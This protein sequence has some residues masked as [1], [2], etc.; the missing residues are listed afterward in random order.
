VELNGLA[1]TLSLV[2]SFFLV[3]L[4]EP[5]FATTFF[6]PPADFEVA[7][8]DCAMGTRSASCLLAIGLSLSGMPSVTKGFAAE[9]TDKR[10][11]VDRRGDPLPP[12]ARLR[13]GTTRWRHGGEIIAL[14]FAPDGRSVATMGHDNTL[15]L[16]DIASGKGLAHFHAPNGVAVAFA[17]DGQSLLWCDARGALYRCGAGRRGEDLAGQSERVHSFTLGSEQIETVAFAPDGSTAAL[18]T[19]GDHV[20]LWGHK[21]EIK[22][23]GG[24][25]ALAMSADGR[26]V[27]MNKGREG[28]ELFDV[29]AKRERRAGLSFGTDAVRS[30]AFAA[31]GRTLAAG[32]YENRIRLWDATTGREIRMLEGH[33]RVPVSGKNGVFCLA[34]APGGTTLASGGADGTVRVWDVKTGKEI[35]CCAG[36]G[37]RV[38]ALA[39]TPDGKGLASGGAD[40]V[41]RLWDPATGREVGPEKGAGGAV[42]G[43]SVSANGQTLAL[44]QMPGRL[45][46][47]DL[48]T[49][50][51]RPKAPRPPAPVSAAVFGPDGQTLVSASVAGHLHFWN[52][53][54]AEELRPT[55]NVQ[56]AVRLL[57]VADNGKTVAFAASDRRIVL[58]DAQAG[59][60]LRQLRPQGNTLS[61]LF[62]SAD[63]QTLLSAGSAGIRLWSVSG[64]ESDRELAEK[65]GGV[66]AAAASPDGRMLATGGEF[67]TV[68][69][70]EVASG[71]QRRAMYGD[72]AFVR[73]AAF[74]ANGH[75]LATGSSNGTVRLWDMSTGQRLHTFAGHRGEV[76]AVAFAGR[77]STLITASQD[78]TAL[79]WDVPGLLEA[80]RSRVIELSERQVQSLW[81]DLGSE[82]APRA[83]EA[84][85]MLSRAPA[86]TVPFL[87]Q[88]VPVVSAEKLNRLLKEL[89]DDKFDVRVQA[90]K[91][92]AQMGKFAEASLRKMLAGKPS[93]EARRRAEELLDLL[94]DPAAMTEYL[95]A[96]RAVEVLEMIGTEP[97]RKLLQGLAEGAAEAPLTREAKAALA[98]LA[99]KSE[100]KP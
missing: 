61:G 85:E 79:V 71:K 80:G 17:K 6:D 93:L 66:F 76:V 1:G 4:S 31:D 57:A 14:A 11:A 37:G 96:L 28:I 97:A 5:N 77:G 49:G 59:K 100:A 52:V 82:D 54:K 60:E 47:W 75:L 63:G 22:G 86:R 26:I 7:R 89:D 62:F 78:G 83:Y 56:S 9:P 64:R 36:H 46:L 2:S 42:T 33:R 44:V 99:R 58:W 38:R 23:R 24:I 90:M 25:Q 81:R 72:T 19:S 30:L 48:T 68:H 50:N 74:S 34:F 41:F 12:L 94:A 29:S 3:L 43:M 73:A 84:V 16:W 88:Q 55:Q 32:D 91:E 92:L 40:N 98:R 39:F 53:A 8:G 70:W 20:L 65:V 13:I 67:G 18:G 21:T 27:A 35:A 69:L 45:S 51:E 15:S 10:P 87:R 95:R